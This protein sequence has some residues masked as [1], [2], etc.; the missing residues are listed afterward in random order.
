MA[1]ATLARLH[2]E[3]AFRADLEAARDELATVRKKG[4]KPNRD[5]SEES[6]ALVIKPSLAQ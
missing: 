4:L 3:P 1:A 6:A 5:C 2:A